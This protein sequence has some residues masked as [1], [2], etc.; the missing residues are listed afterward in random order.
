M[1][2]AAKVLA[3]LAWVAIAG[4]CDDSPAPASSAGGGASSSGRDDDD[5]DDD[6]GEGGAGVGSSTSTGDVVGTTT[7]TTSTSAV[8]STGTGTDASAALYAALD[9][10]VWSAIV[11]IE[12]RTRALELWFDADGRRWSAVRNPFGPSRADVAGEFQIEPDG[13]TVLAVDD[14]SGEVHTW[15]LDVIG[16]SGGTPR[17]L[18]RA[19]D[20]G[21][22][23]FTEGLWPEPVGGLTAELRVFSSSGPVA[24]AYCKAGGCGIDYATLFG[25]ARG[26]DVG[27]DM[28]SDLVA[29]A[30]LHQW[31][32]VDNFAVT[33]VDGF[34]PG[35]LGGTELSDQFNF[36]VRYTGWVEHP[37]GLLSM[38]ELDDDVGEL[39]ATDYGGVWAFIAGDVGVGGFADL[40]LGVNAF[41]FCDDGSDDEPLA[42]GDPQSVPIEIILIRCNTDGPQV[43]VQMS[44]AEGDWL[45]VGDQPTTPDTSVT[46]FPGGL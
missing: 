12:G 14:A 46:L 23:D 28:G 44:L 41:G 10:T 33:D 11:E 20:D 2:R 6:G 21:V 36:V 7:T 29:G 35:T 30:R 25:F 3:V 24:D 32:N 1:T 4:G 45:Y 40:F 9:D 19:T 13:R 22:D 16:G 38:R 26:L 43:D 39:N 31:Y 37:G 27:D 42:E 8:G 5:D 17:T 18:R 34:D 15:D